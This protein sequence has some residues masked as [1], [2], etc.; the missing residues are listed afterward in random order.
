LEDV[1]SAPTV[2]I[3]KVRSLMKSGSDYRIDQAVLMLKRM[4]EIDA[5]LTADQRAKLKHHRRGFFPGMN[6]FDGRGS[7][8]CNSW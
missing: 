3:D 7:C 4:Q 8:P 6:R 5:V 2:D 1:M